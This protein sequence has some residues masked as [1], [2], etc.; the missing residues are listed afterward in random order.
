VFSDASETVVH[1]IAVGFAAYSLRVAYRPPDDDH[2][3]G[4]DKIAYFSSGFEGIL[5]ILAAISII[6]TAVDKLLH[7]IVLTKLSLGS[8]LVAT[9]AIVNGILGWYLLQ[10]SK[11]QNSLI[12]RANAKHI[13]T[14]VWTSFGA[15][16]GLCLADWTGQLWIDPL[17]AFLFALN[18]IYEG[19]KLVRISAEGLMDKTN[20]EAEAK[21]AQ[22]LTEFCKQSDITFHRL[23]L[24]ESGT[25]LYVDFHLQF[26]N[27]T[28][29]EVAHEIAT[30]AEIRISEVFGGTADVI[31]HLES[32]EHDK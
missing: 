17:A 1:L 2:H 4:H 31:S 18:I 19:G 23:R 15:I 12:L 5:I 30:Q 32:M 3:F 13:F 26:P 25:R 8:A 10:T 24:R 29:I 27:N 21:A 16:I 20:P 9:A 22:T 28:T 11:K 6:V 7:G 14:D